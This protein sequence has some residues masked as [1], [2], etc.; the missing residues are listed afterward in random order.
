MRDA[1]LQDF[2]AHG[3]A[4]VAELRAADPIAYLRLCADVFDARPSELMD[5][6]ALVARVRALLAQVGALTASDVDG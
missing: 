2:S 6:A 3:A 4:A 5:D 1:L